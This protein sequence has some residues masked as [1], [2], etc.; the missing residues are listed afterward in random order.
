MLNKTLVFSIAM[1]GYQWRYN[2]LINSHR[3]YCEK[4]GYDYVSVNKPSSTVLGHEVAWL[5][6][7][8]IIKALEKGYRWVVF[9]DADTEIKLSAPAVQTLEC[10]DKHIYMAKGYSGR[11][12][13]GV[14][15]VRNNTASRY[16]FRLVLDN[17]LTPIPLEDQVGWGENGHI[18]HYAKQFSNVQIIGNEWNNNHQESEQDYIRHYSAGP[19]RNTDNPPLR[20]M[21]LYKLHHYSLAALK[22]IKAPYHKISSER[23]GIRLEK[24]SEQVEKHFPEFEGDWRSNS[25]FAPAAFQ[26]KS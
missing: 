18:I 5:K 11:I 16:F 17:A 12:N 4:Q 9:L 19:F 21:I 3:R 8:L 20:S 13:S 7:R 23:F 22:R 1:N 24:L 14:I 2:A 10:N 25:N 15:I 26:T 6:I